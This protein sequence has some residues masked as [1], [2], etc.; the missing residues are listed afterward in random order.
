MGVKLETLSGTEY[1]DEVF[2]KVRLTLESLKQKT[3]ESLFTSSC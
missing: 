2:Q 1:A 3:S